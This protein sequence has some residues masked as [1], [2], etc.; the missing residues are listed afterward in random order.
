MKLSLAFLSIISLL[1]ASR[2]LALPPYYEH[3]HHPVLGRSVERPSTT[4]GKSN[5]QNGPGDPTGGLG[6]LP[7]TAEA[8]MSQGGGQ[9]G[10]GPAILD[11]WLEFGRILS[12][13]P[14]WTKPVGD[15]AWTGLTIVI[16]TFLFSFFRCMGRKWD[17][18]LDGG[19]GEDKNEC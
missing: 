19:S 9:G 17:K 13:G 11:D 5:D 14:T 2:T 6:D 3:K 8:V 16:A 18:M 15:A 12:S 4:S 10:Q 7:T 1:V